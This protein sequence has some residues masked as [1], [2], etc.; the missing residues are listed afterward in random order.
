MIKQLAQGHSYLMIK[1]VM[2][3]RQPRFRTYSLITQPDETLLCVG[4][5]MLSTS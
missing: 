4:P 1:P 3:S 2:E 5:C